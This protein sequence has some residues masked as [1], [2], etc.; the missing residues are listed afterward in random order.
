MGLSCAEMNSARFDTM[1]WSD[2]QMELLYEC[3]AY[4]QE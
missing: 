1:S 3:C 2:K 4:I